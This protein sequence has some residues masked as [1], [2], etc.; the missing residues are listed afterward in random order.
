L[1]D[2]AVPDAL[3]TRTVDPAILA[4]GRGVW[5]QS[6]KEAIDPSLRAKADEAFGKKQSVFRSDIKNDMNLWD[7]VLHQY[8]NWVDVDKPHDWLAEGLGLDPSMDPSRLAR[9]RRRVDSWA[10]RNWTDGLRTFGLD[11]DPITVSPKRAVEDLAHGDVE[12]LGYSLMALREQELRGRRMGKRLTDKQLQAGLDLYNSDSGIRQAV[13]A[14]QDY[15]EKWLK[16]LETEGLVPEGGAARIRAE[17]NYWFAPFK[18]IDLDRMNKRLFGSNIPTMS[19]P[20]TKMARIGHEAGERIMYENPV[21]AWAEYTFK[22]SRAVARKRLHTSIATIGDLSE[23]ISLRG[24][25]VRAKGLISKVTPEDLPKSAEPYTSGSG[26]FDDLAPDVMDDQLLQAK[27]G[28]YYFRYVQKTGKA[29]YYEVDKFLYESLRDTEGV[30]LSENLLLRTLLAPGR[31]LR[32]G[33]TVTP[34]F[35]ASNIWRDSTF[36]A[37]TDQTLGAGYPDSGVA[38]FAD[39]LSG[40][41]RSIDNLFKDALHKVGADIPWIKN[42]AEDPNFRSMELSGGSMSTLADM[43]EDKIIKV[44]DD[45]RRKMPGYTAKLYR[46]QRIGRELG[47]DMKV[48]GAIGENANRLDTFT[49]VRDGMLAKGYKQLDAN[50]EGAYRAGEATVDFSRKGRLF[51]TSKLVKALDTG[52]AF[53]RAG[54]QGWDRTI[55]QVVDIDRHG[56]QLQSYAQLRKTGVVGATMTSMALLNYAYNR[57]N[58]DYFDV[59]KDIRARYVLFDV[60]RTGGYVE[61]AVQGLVGE[62]ADLPILQ[63]GSSLFLKIPLPHELGWLFATGP[64]RMLEEL[65]DANPSHSDKTGIVDAF[66]QGLDPIGESLGQLV[67]PGAF[68]DSSFGGTGLGTYWQIKTNQDLFRDMPIEPPYSR[69]L[70]ADLRMRGTESYGAQALSEGMMK[71]GLPA[72]SPGQIDLAVRSMG[73]GLAGFGLDIVGMADPTRESHSLSQSAPLRRF[74]VD[75]RSK[76][77][78]GEAF[79]D[80]Y[81]DLKAKIDASRDYEDRGQPDRAAKILGEIEP[82]DL[83]RYQVMEVLYENLREMNVAQQSILNNGDMT[84]DEKRDINTAIRAEAELILKGATYTDEEAW[85]ELR[86]RDENPE[87]RMLVNS[88]LE[89][90]EDEKKKTTRIRRAIK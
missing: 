39:A 8:M 40:G 38:A 79:Y 48:F 80:T 3:E 50:I 46:L 58:P 45:M 22:M 76:G 15:S 28:T 7:R 17:G 65:D 6:Q 14:F 49:R 13:H 61:Q 34:N 4:E 42:I 63:Q 24:D 33:V 12:G 89:Y 78:A 35:A 59:K 73:G 56:L 36:R 85:L 71:V 67:G 11:E 23:E 54:I 62:D 55:R 81:F 1:V 9:V 52:T 19:D 66:R 90:F 32:T 82:L 27:N 44:M 41:V 31:M 84:N 51:E 43:D 75:D 21:V 86:E 87:R 37:M 57:S 18:R 30:Q 10:V 68:W 83:A 29:D 53:W 26:L 47:H 16:M 72:R 64:I 88:L 74:F 20:L 77:M 69:D 70:P 25:M 5:V 2:D 60:G